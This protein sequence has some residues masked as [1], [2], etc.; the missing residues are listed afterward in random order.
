MQ[1][2]VHDY[3]DSKYAYALTEGDA[4]TVRTI[5]LLGIFFTISL[6]A[7]CCLFAFQSWLTAVLFVP[8]FFIVIVY[9]LLDAVILAQYPGFSIATH[10]RTV[11]H[12]RSGNVFPK[13]AVMI[14]AA[15]EDVQIVQKTVAGAVA[16]DYPNFTAFL[17]D[18]SKEAIYH[19]M[20]AANGATYF[21]RQRTGYHKKAGNLNAL[22]NKLE[23][24]AY[25]Y[26]LVLDADFVPD[27]DILNELVPYASPNVGIV[28][29]PQHFAMTK[30]VYQRSKFE[31]GA[32]MIQ[33]DFYRITQTARNELHGAICVGTNAL[34][35][36]EALRKVGGYEGV[37]RKEWG[38][39][40]DVNTGLKMINTT[41]GL[42]Q[43]YRI[44]YIPVRL[45]TGICPDD[46][47]SFY[48]QQNRWATGSMQLIFS[49]K[50]LFS[51]HLTPRQKIC[52]L[53]NSAY[54]FY[55][56]ALLA[57]PLQ[58]LVLLVA[59]HPFDWQSTL[60]FLPSLLLTTVLA[61]YMLRRQIRPVASSLVVLSNAYTFAQALY[62]LA[63]KRPLGWEATGATGAKK[64]NVRFTQFK[65]FSSLFFIGIY[66]SV[67]V[68][69]IINQSLQLTPSLII[70]ALFLIA[71]VS[72]LIYLHYMLAS[73]LTR[74]QLFTD[75]HTYMYAAILL[76]I[77]FATS[78]SVMAASTYDIK[79]SGNKILLR[80]K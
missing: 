55:T 72:H 52:Y 31:Y 19:D 44:Q 37:G 77:G 18:D 13:V 60:L 66:V 10:R 34:Y 46:H 9:N 32:A 1:F 47:L 15:G 69:L 36:I 49:R 73:R 78:A 41:N 17:L 61:P 42:G 67:F 59:D 35:S 70:C 24:Q 22:L 23:G 40:E 29:S 7:G 71:F 56:I 21:R 5:G 14:P 75:R 68:A 54:Y 39:S 63:I 62:L 53:A 3:K 25:D 4:H 43:R 79:I 65:I 26:V 76:I 11:A 2:R 50:T 20:V 80:D 64:R 33:R 57:S 28:Q 51:P 38:H 48:K 58:L 12:F 45:A 8:F 30:E 74:K 6:A 16:I 27:K